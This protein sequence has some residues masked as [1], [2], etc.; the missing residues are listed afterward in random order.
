M[1]RSPKLLFLFCIYL[2]F[3]SEPAIAD[4]L[5]DAKREFET[6]NYVGAARLFIPLAENGDAFAR[7]KLA[8]MYRKGQGVQQDYK[9]AL[10]WNRLA[11]EQGFAKAQNNLGA[12]YANGHGVAQDYNEAMKWYRLAAEQGY[13]IAQNNLG[14]MYDNGFGV[15]RDIHEAKKWYKKAADQGH[16]EAQFNLEYLDSDKN[17]L[18]PDDAESV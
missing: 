15:P 12:M 18:S 16:R 3:S 6:G 7:F 2:L 11:A 10:K 14:E 8:V 9:K 4:P 13:D 5:S 1:S 17:I